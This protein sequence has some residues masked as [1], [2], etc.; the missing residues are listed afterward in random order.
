MLVKQLKRRRQEALIGFFIMIGTYLLMV[1][2]VLMIENYN[3]EMQKLQ[4][5]F[6]IGTLATMV[7]CFFL[8]LFVDSFW[9]LGEFNMAISMGQTRKSFVWCYE[10]VSVLELFGMIGILR[11]LAAVEEG[12]Y[13]WLLPGAKIII[14][15]DVIFQWRILVGIVLG[16]IAL[17]ML[18]QAMLLRYGMKVLWVMWIVWMLVAYTPHFL[19]RNSGFAGMVNQIMGWG[20]WMIGRFGGNFWIGVGAGI[21]GV[22]VGIAWKFLRRQQVTM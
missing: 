10:L 15:A 16:M 17:Q 9:F 2:G 13:H 14:A 7:V 6:V 12:V 8:Q 1:V 22:I 11:G 5:V 4:Q 20:F 19:S 3:K 18:I 21:A